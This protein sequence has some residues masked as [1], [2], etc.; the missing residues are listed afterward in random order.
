MVSRIC[1]DGFPWVGLTR[2]PSATHRLVNL[3]K[4]LGMGE[5]YIKRD[6]QCGLW[7]GGNKPRKL[8]FLLGDALAR[9]SGAVVTFGGLGSNHALAT[10]ICARKL[11]AC[12]RS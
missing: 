1:E 3:G 12:A 2:T 11:G 9:G 8:E 5:L 6:D 4:V 10:A 7:Y